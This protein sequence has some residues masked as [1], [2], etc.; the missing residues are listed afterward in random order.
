MDLEEEFDFRKI[1]VDVY[2]AF[3][4]HDCDCALGYPGEGF[5][6][7][8]GSKTVEKKSSK[9][10]FIPDCTSSFKLEFDPLLPN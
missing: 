2:Q 9:A 4:R 5:V 6:E 8:V 3:V 1:G 7:G 10:K